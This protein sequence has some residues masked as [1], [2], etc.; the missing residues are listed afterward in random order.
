MSNTERLEGLYVITDDKLTPKDKL[1]EMV[2]ASLKG[3]ASIV[4]L[5]DKSSSDE[6]IKATSLA[7]QKLC[8]YYDAL[9]VLNDK[10]DIAIECKLDGLHIGKSDHHRFEE[11][12]KNFD[13]I[14]GVSCYGDIPL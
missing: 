1:L 14:I 5:R 2:E 6:E 11:I 10:I 8:H 12:R 9:F 3:G 4:Q 13:G 7:L